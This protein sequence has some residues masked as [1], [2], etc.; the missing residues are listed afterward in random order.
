M[1]LATRSA[2]PALRA[3]LRTEVSGQDRVP[4]HG[5]V[6]LA[7]NHR[8][9][10]DHFLLAAASPRPMRFLGKASMA[11]GI[12]GRL[13]V[14]MGMIPVE[15]GHA[16]RAALE[17]AVWILRRGGVIGLFPEGTRS[18]TGEL[19][20]FRSGLARIAAAARVPVV[21][22]ALIGTADV[23]PRSR[24]LPRRPPGCTTAVRFGDLVPPPEGDPVSRR[25]FTAAVR[26]RVAALCEQPLADRFGPVADDEGVPARA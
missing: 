8:S 16:D 18:P 22:V 7:A 14:M 17:A 26:E 21:P 20:R 6:L 4:G 10:L 19:Y 25:D 15:R 1:R 13:N 2:G 9:F 5:G 24:R 11:Q 12:T 3:Y 23:L